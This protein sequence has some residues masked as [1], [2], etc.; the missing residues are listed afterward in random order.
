MYRLKNPRLS[1]KSHRYEKVGS[2]LQIPSSILRGLSC[3][4]AQL[5]LQ[6]LIHPRSGG[7]TCSTRPPAQ[8]KAISYESQRISWRHFAF[9]VLGH[10]VAHCRHRFGS[11][12]GQS[13][14]TDSLHGTHSLLAHIR[15]PPA[16]GA[17]VITIATAAATAA[18]APPARNLV[19]RPLGIFCIL[20]ASKLRRFEGR[21][22]RRGHVFL[23]SFLPSHPF[24]LVLSS[25]EEIMAQSK[26]AL[27]T[28]AAV[29][30]IATLTHTLRKEFHVFRGGSNFVYRIHRDPLCFLSK[31]QPKLR[32]GIGEVGPKTPRRGRLWGFLSQGLGDVGRTV[33]PAWSDRTDFQFWSPKEARGTAA[34]RAAL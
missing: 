11:I 21:G 12:E 29:A 6:I 1:T 23:V 28:A 9:I 15:Q 7:Q 24:A 26:C 3:P 4:F 31:S 25:L 18:G 16:N 8:T 17:V 10:A 32:P 22:P 27:L 14:P 13:L 2:S 20:F 33:P 5:R 34:A 19:P 30:A